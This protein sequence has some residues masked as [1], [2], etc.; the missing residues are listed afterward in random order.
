MIVKRIGVMSSA[1]VSGFLY[2]GM[3]LILGF[4]MSFVS[5]FGLAFGRAIDQGNGVEPI[6]GAMFGLGAIVLLP[7]VYGAMGFVMGAFTAAIYNL[8]ARA[9]GG[10]EIEL[11]AV[12]TPAPA[13][14]HPE[15]PPPPPY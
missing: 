13:E 12:P 11:V 8:V 7:L 9:I 1:K 6:V 2:A 4:F 10:L 3:G 15:A 14:T 5:L